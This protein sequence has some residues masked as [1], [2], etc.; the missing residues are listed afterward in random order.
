MNGPSPPPA[1]KTALPK[2]TSPPSRTTIGKSLIPLQKSMTRPNILRNASENKVYTGKGKVENGSNSMPLPIVGTKTIQSTGSSRTVHIPGLPS[3]LTI[4]RIE[5]DSIVCIRCRNPGQCHV[6][7]YNKSC[8]YI[9]L[10][11]ERGVGGESWI[12][13]FYKLELLT[14]RCLRDIATF[15]KKQSIQG[16]VFK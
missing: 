7:L 16:E 5:N 12:G 10:M 2:S 3:S 6:L 13:F 11:R 14:F 8:T 1:S 9:S 4:E 15:W